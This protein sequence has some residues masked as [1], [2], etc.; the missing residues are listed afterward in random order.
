VEP[1][2]TAPAIQIMLVKGVDVAVPFARPLAALVTLIMQAPTIT[3]IPT[4]TLISTVRLIST[5]MPVAPI[6]IVG[7]RRDLHREQ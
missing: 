4:I 3:P 1:A 7:I 2:A 6:E 5:V